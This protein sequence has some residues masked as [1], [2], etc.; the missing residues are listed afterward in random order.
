MRTLRLINIFRAMC[1]TLL[2]TGCTSE[3]S[4][5]TE[6]EEYAQLV[7]TVG[8]G[9]S[10]GKQAMK[11]SR[12]E[13]FDNEDD[14]WGVAGE[15]IEEL[16]VIILDGDN[17]VEANRLFGLDDTTQSNQ[18]TFT[19]KKNDTK[20]VLLLANEGD[21]LLDGE[22]LPA[23]SPRRLKDY[24]ETID[25]NVMMTDSE[26]ERL[27]IKL[28]DNSRIPS[29]VNGNNFS[30]RTPL[31]I[32]AV[33]KEHIG[34]A[35]VTERT[36]DIHRAAVKYS[37]RI[38]NKSRYDHKL[39]G[40]RISRIADR[41]FLFPNAK[42][43][44]NELG[45][46]VIDSY[47]VPTATKENEYKITDLAVN[48]PA[49]MTTGIQALEPIYVPEGRP[50]SKDT[51]KVSISLTGD[52]L[53]VWRNLKWIMPGE[54]QASERPMVDLPRNSHVVVNIT[55]TDND[56]IFIADVQPYANVPLEPPFGLDRDDEGN[57]I[58]KRY[59]DGTYEIMVDGDS[60]RKDAD[61]DE[62]LK[63]FSDSTF[64]C[65]TEVLKDYIHDE[66]VETDYI[67]YFEKD[68]SGG[69]MIL[70]RQKSAGGTYHGGVDDLTASTH[71]HD[72]NDRPLFVIDKEGKFF[73]V[74]YDDK[75]NPTL[76]NKDDDGAEIIQANGYQFRNSGDMKKYI[77]TYIVKIGDTEELRHYQTGKKVDWNTGIAS[78]AAATTRTAA[79]KAIMRRM[80]QTTAKLLNALNKK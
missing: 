3:L 33:Y 1:V 61:G 51:V 47:T 50:T 25:K 20:T 21:Y 53:D 57:I 13:G 64:L 5:S 6:K 67:Y 70:I 71:D 74:Y 41:E 29:A 72:M 69:N 38:I 27:I 24:L 58:T 7:L 37:F 49:R 36:Y 10:D 30:L 26:L 80:H 62:V 4:E 54:T 31:P 45:H 32:S 22:T 52:T 48:L 8:L 15:N 17:N 78:S 65:K 73:K 14:K 55:I 11:A 19:V 60:I 56:I 77:G 35:K 34:E 39:E 23:G 75:G 9:D 16:R 18:Y 46:T 2:L 63:K 66:N 79:P 40:I 42:Y 76:S 68:K 12:M 59:P 43:T 44:T 28:E